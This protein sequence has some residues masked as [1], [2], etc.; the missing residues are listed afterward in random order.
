M[1][2]GGVRARMDARRARRVL[3]RGH[4][5]RVVVVVVVTAG[6]VML[7]HFISAGCADWD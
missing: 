3:N 1:E 2:F 6:I 7:G 5:M 4:M